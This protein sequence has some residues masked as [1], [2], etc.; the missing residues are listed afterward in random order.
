AFAPSRRRSVLGLVKRIAERQPDWVI[1]QFNQFSFGRWGLN[2]LLPLALKRIK[3]RC[4]QTRLGVM[5]HEDFVPPITWKFRIMRIWQKW[6][7]KSIGRTADVVF[8]SISPWVTRY[9][10]WF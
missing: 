7:F 10:G 8:F 9:G 3:R 5:F 1:L 4:P 2:P 6:P